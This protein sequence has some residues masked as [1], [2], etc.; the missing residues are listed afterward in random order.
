MLTSV[1]IFA[2][3]SRLDGLP[4]AIVLAGAFMRG[5]G[6]SIK[7]Y[8]EFYRDSWSELQLQSRP[9]RQYQHS[10]VIQTWRISYLEIKKRDPNA[11]ALLLLLARFDNRD[12]WY[13]LVESGH[14]SSNVPD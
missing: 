6:T 3:A 9:G 8:L 10:N 2:L 13:E 12:I 5:I 1:D 11:A 4:L 7:E 14:H